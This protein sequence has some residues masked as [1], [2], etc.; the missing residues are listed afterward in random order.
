M[1]KEILRSYQKLER[2]KEKIL[3]LL[4]GVSHEKLNQKLNDQKWSILQVLYHMKEAEKQPLAYMKKKTLDPKA[5]YPSTLK[6][7]FRSYL[8]R[9]SL[10]LPLKFEAPKS[11]KDNI[12]GEIKLEELKKDWDQ[13]RKD[14]QTFLNNL[15]PTLYDK[16]IFKH[17]KVG[18]INLRQTMVF[19]QS[20]FDHHVPQ[21]KG[22]LKN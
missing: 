17:P 22:L 11:V 21:V 9:I 1:N 8:L 16:K 10:F 20:H 6:Q 13:V 7:Q 18:M 4:E 12:P 2:S 19:F 5:L 15:D 14:M 3:G